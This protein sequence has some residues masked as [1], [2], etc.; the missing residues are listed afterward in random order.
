[1][2]DNGAF[3]GKAFRVFLF[4]F[5]KRFGNEQG[6][7]R[8]NMPGRFEHIVERPL[9]LFPDRVTVRLDDHAAADGRILSEVSTLDDLVVPLGIVLR[10]CWKPFCHIC[11]D[12]T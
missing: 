10:S 12:L 8:I 2:R 1:M 7:V 5:E 6:K 9:H 11:P 3:L 4:F